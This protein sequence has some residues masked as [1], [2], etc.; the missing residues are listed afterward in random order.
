MKK[1]CNNILNSIHNSIY[2]KCDLSHVEY[3]TQETQL[4]TFGI[5]KINSVRPSL[6]VQRKMVAQTGF[7]ISD[8]RWG[9][10]KSAN[11]ASRLVG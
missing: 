6:V 1:K 4:V 2:V 11:Y 5:A 8:I 9:S 10:H 7:I 3:N